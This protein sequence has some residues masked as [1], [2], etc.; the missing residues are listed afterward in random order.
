MIQAFYKE[1]CT[2]CQCCSETLITKVKYLNTSDTILI[3]YQS[4][5]CE[6]FKTQE[7][8]MSSHKLLIN[9]LYRGNNWGQT[10]C[11]WLITVANHTATVDGLAKAFSYFFLCH[12][13]HIFVHF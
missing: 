3:T 7:F 11:R 6:L 12:L 5:L 10:D 8:E 9:R 4:V 2:L 1:A 13:I